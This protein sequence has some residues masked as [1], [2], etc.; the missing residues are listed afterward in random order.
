MIPSKF[1][2]QL[3]EDFCKA[4]KRQFWLDYDGSLVPFAQRPTEAPPSPDV[5]NLLHRLITDPRNQ[6]III[7]GRDAGSMEQ[8][9]GGI[10]L[11]LV[12][13]HGAFIRRRNQGWQPYLTA[14]ATWKPSLLPTL[15]S[16]IEHYAGSYLEEKTFSMVW[17]YREVAERIWPEDV[18]LAID[19]LQVASLNKEIAIYREACSVEVRSRGIDKGSF[20]RQ[21]P[22]AGQPVDF[23]LVLGDGHTDEDLF[24]QAPSSFYTVKVGSSANTA[25]KL[26]IPFQ[27]DVLPFLSRLEASS[28]SAAP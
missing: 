28:G 18:S 25:A 16:L 7:S 4:T 6:V 23:G 11:D 10:S 17:H 20:F 5:L 1:E 26:S 13:E 14:S 19:A 3:T 9:L 22:W 15:Q 2:Q 21:S 27:R 8:W 24:V 12:A